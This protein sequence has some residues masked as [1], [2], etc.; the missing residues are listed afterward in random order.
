MARLHQI[1]RDIPNFKDLKAGQCTQIDFILE[2][3]HIKRCPKL[4]ISNRIK[5][6]EDHAYA[7][8]F[9]NSKGQKTTRY[10][11][12]LWYAEN[13]R[14]VALKGKETWTNYEKTRGP[15]GTNAKVY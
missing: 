7:V 1:F 9:V 2:K 10:F 6:C 3:P 13:F 8:T 12:K 15:F 4:A 14:K 11:D 5:L